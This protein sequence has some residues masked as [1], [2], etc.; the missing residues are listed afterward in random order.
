MRDVYVV[1]SKKKTPSSSPPRSLPEQYGGC[2]KSMVSN[3]R[4]FQ[5]PSR[6][7][8]A[9]VHSGFV[10]QSEFDSVAHSNLVV[11]FAEV[12]PDNMFADFKFP[13]DFAIFQSLGNQLNNS[14]LASTGLPW[15]VPIHW[16]FLN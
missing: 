15:S 13:S 5:I 1:L 16:P 4:G 10:P 12:V 3:S 11:N 7:R 6:H 8:L 14:Q 2:N 9:F